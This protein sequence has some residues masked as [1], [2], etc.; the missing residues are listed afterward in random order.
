MILLVNLAGEFVNFIL[1]FLLH[2]FVILKNKSSRHPIT[3]KSFAATFRHKHFREYENS[4]KHLTRALQFERAVK[5][6]SEFDASS[7]TGLCKESKRNLCLI[8][9]NPSNKND[10]D[11]NNE[12]FDDEKILKK[13]NDKIEEEKPYG[14]KCLIK[15]NSNCKCIIRPHSDFLPWTSSSLA[16]SSSST[17]NDNDNDNDDRDN[18]ESIRE[19]SK[20]NLDKKLKRS[21]DNDDVRID[22]RW[23][24]YYLSPL[25]IKNI[26]FITENNECSPFHWLVIDVTNKEEM[27]FLKT[28]SSTNSFIRLLL[29]INGLVSFLSIRVVACAY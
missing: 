12:K 16:T 23:M 13:L 28:I 5:L 3:N 14:C 18:C 25:E 10:Q 2:S 9:L 7:E 27:M 15:P 4:P 11:N 6:E 17:S 19:I 22:K 1:L 21:T 26:A 20:K 29:D 24:Q 8:Q